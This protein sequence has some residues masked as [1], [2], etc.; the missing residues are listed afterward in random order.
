MARLVKLQPESAL[1]NYYFGL[2]L[3]DNQARVALEL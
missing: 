1:A 3:P 2:T